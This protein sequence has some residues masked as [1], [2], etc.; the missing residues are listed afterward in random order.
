MKF[1]LLTAALATTVTLYIGYRVLLAPV[2][3]RN[4]YMKQEVL[5]DFIYDHR[6]KKEKQ[7]TEAPLNFLSTTNELVNNDEAKD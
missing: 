2:L 7:E 5:A 4:Y 6:S 1:P 3:K